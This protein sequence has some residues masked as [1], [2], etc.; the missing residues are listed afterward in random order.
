MN[1]FGISEKSLQLILQ[2]LEEYSDVEEAYIFGSRAKGNYRLGSDIDIAIKTLHP[3]VGIAWSISGILNE[4]LPIPY[5]V[6]V[7]DYTTLIHTDLKKH[8][9]RFGKILFSRQKKTS[10]ADN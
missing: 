1:D 9:D 2:T 4:R 6:D 8:I 5:K 3:D 10:E 7:V